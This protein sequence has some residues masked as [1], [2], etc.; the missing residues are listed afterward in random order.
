MTIAT[1]SPDIDR[2]AW[3]AE[4][5]NGIGASEAAA[6][7][8]VSPY[9]T[10]LDLFLRKTGQKPPVETTRA[11]MIGLLME[12]VLAELY[13]EETGVGFAD[14]Q[15]FRRSELVPWMF[16]TLDRVRTDGRI[17]E[18]K[19]AGARVASEWGEAGSDQ[20]PAH[21]LVQVIHQMVV[22]EATVADVAVLIGGQ[23]FRVYTVE[24]DDA[25]AERLVELESAFWSHVRQQ[26]PPEFDAA[27]DAENLVYLYP[28]SVG[29]LIIENDY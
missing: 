3:L 12:P 13:S 2:A 7:I 11:M 25:V 26:V 22:A 20:I 4:R 19:T 6:A 29:E 16:A 28:E 21:Y 9:D 18:L 10:P 14:A 1:I 8:G 23:D 5:Q 27:K 15:A 17:V 24:R